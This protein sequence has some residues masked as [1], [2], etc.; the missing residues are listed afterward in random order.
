MPSLRQIRRRIRSVENTKKI[1]RA[2][3]MVAASKR[4]RFEELLTKA[5]A[6]ASFLEKLFRNL[7]TDVSDYHHPL[8]EKKEGS[9][10]LALV[11][12]TSDT[13]LC[14][15]YNSNL[16]HEAV[17][18]LNTQKQKTTEIIAVGRSGLNFFQRRGE[19][20][21]VAFTEIKLSNFEQTARNVTEYVTQEFVAGRFEEVYVLYT[22]F[23]S[24]SSYQPR[25]EKFLN[26]EKLPEAVQKRV[27]YILEP[28]AER[29]FEELLPKF[30]LSKVRTALLE[31]FLSE[32]ISRMMAMRQATDNAVEMIEDLTLLRNKL[33][34]A[35]I[36]KELIEVVSGAKALKS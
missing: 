2:M 23:L 32:Q 19:K 27:D 7:L 17:V 5:R 8:F 4:R 31:A 1:T 15:T 6:S 29:V 30:L 22:Q 35:S 11:V 18:F 36:T 3:E 26:L 16:L 34:Q 10:H 24:K 12:V 20:V 14:G 25:L 9:N 13:G 28:S 33:R 21:E